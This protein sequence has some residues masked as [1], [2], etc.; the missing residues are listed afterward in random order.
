MNEDSDSSSKYEDTFDNK[1]DLMYY[2]QNVERFDDEKEQY[3]DENEDVFKNN[4]GVRRTAS[5]SNIIQEVT[6]E[7]EDVDDIKVNSIPKSFST[8]TK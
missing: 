8:K 6:N 7:E 3:D 2:Q 4:R 1:Q 5:F